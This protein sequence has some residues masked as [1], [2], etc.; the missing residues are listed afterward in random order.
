M[1]GRHALGGIWF[2]VDAQRL[3]PT[4][5][6]CAPTDRET[7]ADRRERLGLIRPA[8]AT[9]TINDSIR[10]L[11]GNMTVRQLAYYNGMSQAAAELEAARARVEAMFSNSRDR[12]AEIETAARKL[13]EATGESLADALSRTADVVAREDH[14]KITL[15]LNPR[16]GRAV[17]L[18]SRE[19]VQRY[20][21]GVSYDEEAY[22]RGPLGHVNAP[23]SVEPS[24]SPWSGDGPHDWQ[25]IDPSEDTRETSKCTRCGARRH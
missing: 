2:P 8:H 15:G 5:R 16:T 12:I 17:T 11:L 19:Q 10:A 18:S 22:R 6:V 20:L 14:A 3:H 1:T 21:D 4:R 9:R 23:C 25:P 7:Y 13:A 24:C